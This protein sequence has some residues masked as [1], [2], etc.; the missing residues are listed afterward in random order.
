M[1]TVASYHGNVGTNG[2]LHQVHS[3]YYSY[4][5]N[6]AKMLSPALHYSAKTCKMFFKYQ[7]GLAHGWMKPFFILPKSPSCS[8]P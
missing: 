8:L 6:P 1:E 5:G 7:V 4:Y 2:D 3:G